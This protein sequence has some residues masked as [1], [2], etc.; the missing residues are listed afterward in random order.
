MQGL[1]QRELAERSG[2][3]QSTIARIERG[4]NTVLIHL[5]EIAFALN[6]RVKISLRGLIVPYHTNYDRG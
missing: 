3:P 1:S 6:K 2:V 5:V 4:Y